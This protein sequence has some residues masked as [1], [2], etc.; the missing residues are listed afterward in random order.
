LCGQACRSWSL[1]DLIQF[2]SSANL[3]TFDWELPKTNGLV[4]SR[5]PP[6]SQLIFDGHRPFHPP[7][8]RTTDWRWGPTPALI[9]SVSGGGGPAAAVAGSRWSRSRGLVALARALGRRG[10]VAGRVHQ[11]RCGGSV[12]LGAQPLEHG[13]VVQV[14]TRL[15]FGTITNAGRGALHP[16]QV[17]GIG[18]QQPSAPDLDR[19]RAS[20][21]S[22]GGAPAV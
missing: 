16:D 10:L 1:A 6:I 18:D 4:G 17:F 8:G 2:T 12:R 15:G 11:S 13:D 14:L 19:D 20:D 5:L 9:V 21:C 22:Y 7:T 3:A